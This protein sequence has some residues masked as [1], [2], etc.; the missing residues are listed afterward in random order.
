MSVYLL[1]DFGASR[2][3]AALS[4]NEKIIA[5]SDY[6]AI[7][8]CNTKDKNYE[9]S[10][11]EIKNKFLEIVNYYYKQSHFEGIFICS[12]MH[13]FVVVDKNNMPQSNYI[14]WKSERSTFGD[15][16]NFNKLKS[17]IENTFFT[18]TGMNPRACYPIFNLYDML[19]KDE[20]KGGKIIS[21]PDW[22]ACAGNKSENKTHITMAAGLGFCNIHTKEWDEDLIREMKYPISFNEIVNNIEIGGF[23]NIN[24]EEIPIYTGVGDHQ[25]AV[26]GAGN[27]QNTISVNLGTGSQVAII[28]LKNNHCEKRPYFD[29]TLMGVITHIPSGR[30]LNNFISFLQNINP[31]VD[32]WKELAGIT[33]KQLE[34]ADLSMDLGIFESAWKY[35]DGG[36]IGNIGETNFTKENYLASLLKNYIIQYKH[37]IE[38]LNPPEDCDKI[39]LS[40]G[41]PNKLPV[42]AEYLENIMNK[43]KHG[44]SVVYNVSEY[45]E[46]ILGLKVL[47]DKYLGRNI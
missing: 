31:N 1:L 19:E 39:I 46:T 9:V 5:M 37:A 11:S 10:G 47:K 45:D 22:L 17:K 43:E 2:I 25:C 30:M 38:E 35:S 28:N 24:G 14:S 23:I 12:E 41:I 27:T 7:E 18:K 8:P 15:S 13:G 40:G 33:V 29:N 21:L 36:F 34:K 6:P 3:K 32:F 4:D 42:V 26:L 16:P 20:L 44:Y